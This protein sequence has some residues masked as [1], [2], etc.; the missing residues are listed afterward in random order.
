MK[1]TNDMNSEMKDFAAL[2]DKYLLENI[3]GETKNIWDAARHYVYGGGKRIRPYLVMKSFELVNGGISDQQQIVSIASAL[4]SVH[5]FTLIHDDVIDGDE[6]RRGKP[7][8]HVKW[9]IP[10]AILS[11]DLLF[12]ISLRMVQNSSFDADIKNSIMSDISKVIIELCEG[13]ML[14]V[15]FEKRD[16]VKPD[17]YIRMI[18]LKTAALFRT[19]LATG[20]VAAKAPIEQLEA[21]SSYGENI[22]LAFQL[23]DDILGICGETGKLGK[24][25]GSD[26]K[27]GKKTYILLS[28]MEILKGE[29]LT[30]FESLMSIKVKSQNEIEKITKIIID[31]GA[32][33]KAEKL[34]SQYV[35]NAVESLKIFPDYDAKQGLIELAKFIVERDL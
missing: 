22:G 27:R 26:I 29:R 19:S 23:V 3:S 1:S 34:S 32:V 25:V 20:A 6:I 31:C 21:V 14:D 13:Q 8:V 7:A 18:Y 30:E 16:N 5:T 4:E 2:V 33:D 9:D 17:E 24:T 12:A 15:D 11:G 35:K 10:T 28:A